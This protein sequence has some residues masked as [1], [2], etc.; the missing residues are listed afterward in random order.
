MP[1]R[2]PPRPDS[3]LPAVIHRESAP[4]QAW[5][6]SQPP[7]NYYNGE[8][9]F[10]EP[11]VPL[12]HY[13]WI[14]KR[15]RYKIMAFIAVCVFGTYFVSSRLTP[16]YEATTTVDVD[17]QA[18]SGVVGQDSQRNNVGNDSDQFLAT[19]VKLIQSDSVLRPVAEKYNL[20]EREKQFS[21]NVSKEST[22]NA[23]VLLKQL[24]VSRPPNTYLLLI[25]YRSADPNLA[26]EVANATARSYLEHT[27][28]I[29]IRSSASL[30]TFMEKQIE[31]LKAKMEV[32]SAALLRFER[33]MNIINPEEKTNILSSRLLQLN[34]EYTSAQGDRVRKEVAY[35]SAK[36]GTEEAAMTPS[37]ASR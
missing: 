19:Q 20:L 21:N 3:E 29:R 17:R 4:P 26:A 11:G 12:A 14:L 37:K 8:P 34:T 32:S 1:D 13:Y 6:N 35:Q 24:K 2:T 18:P 31:E 23:P 10:E 27:Y 25:S 30:A 36:V 33:E 7:P 9:E 15:H 22:A 28:N 5:Q 16:I